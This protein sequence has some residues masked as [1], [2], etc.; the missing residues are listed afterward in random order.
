M[1]MRKVIITVAT[2]GGVHRKDKNPSL[3]EQPEEIAESVCESF[4]EGAAI[5][6]I[7]GRDK[8]GAPSGDPEVY[9]EISKRIQGK[10]DIVIQYSTGGG[11]NLDIEQR[12]CC[13]EANPEMA[14]LN[15]GSLLRTVGPYAGTYFVNTSEDIERYAKEMLKRDIKPEMEVYHHGM[16]REVNNLISKGLVK[17]PYYINFV[18]GMAYQGAVAATSESLFSFK[19]LLPPDS[20]FNCCAVGPA[21]TTMVTLSILIGGNGR[22][23]LEDNI[24]YAKGVLAESNAQLVGRIVRLAK[25][26]G[27]EIA[28]PDEAREILGLKKKNS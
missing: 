8:E 5:A 25:D 16:L 4:N 12:L 9:K 23:G 3:P 18:L 1:N 26:L 13:L 10:C 14:S 15:M 11:G 21:Q 2:T 17:K 22:V 6:H 20:I 28:S 27:L 19:S 24:Y 7:H